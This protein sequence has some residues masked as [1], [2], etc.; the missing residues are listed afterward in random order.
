MLSA[1]GSFLWQMCLHYDDGNVCGNSIDGAAF[2]K[3][4]ALQNMV[5]IWIPR[6]AFPEMLVEVSSLL[7]D[8]PRARIPVLH[9]CWRLF[10][11]RSWSLGMVRYVVA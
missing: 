8:S 3:V 10:I 4:R 2:P 11:N 5:V 9:L 6:A 7:H 1:S